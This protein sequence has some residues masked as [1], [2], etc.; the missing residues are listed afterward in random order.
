MKGET[1]TKWIGSRFGSKNG[2]LSF[3]QIAQ[4]LSFSFCQKETER[5]K[6]KEL[7]RY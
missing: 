3:R 4:S 1:G 6:E 2:L 7:N 5:L